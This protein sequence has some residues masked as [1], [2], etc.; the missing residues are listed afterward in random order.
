MM[1]GTRLR[2]LWLVVYSKISST[3]AQS[4]KRGHV[5]RGS[6]S[7]KDRLESPMGLE[8][9]ISRLPLTMKRT[10]CF[11]S[12]DLM[13]TYILL[14]CYI[15]REYCVKSDIWRVTGSF[16]ANARV[17]SSLRHRHSM[18]LG[19]CK[20]L[21]M[22]AS[23]KYTEFKCKMSFIFMCSSVSTPAKWESW[24]RKEPQ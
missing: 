5:W 20:S 21:W 1:L 18:L 10:L 24:Y 6:L 2:R 4:G 19:L 8:N 22:R 7:D 15:F 14:L 9:W 23:A 13:Y 11:I 12:L 16:P 17:E 3:G